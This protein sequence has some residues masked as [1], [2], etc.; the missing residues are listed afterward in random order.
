MGDVRIPFCLIFSLGSDDRVYAMRDAG[1]EQNIFF[2]GRR[3]WLVCGDWMK[4]LCVILWEKRGKRWERMGGERRRRVG[5]A[6]R[7]V[8]SPEFLFFVF[9]MHHTSHYQ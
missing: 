7:T 5:R 1:G 3:D 4:T 8:V 6:K 2:G 9:N